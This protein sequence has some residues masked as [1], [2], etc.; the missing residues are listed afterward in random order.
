MPFFEY[1]DSVTGQPVVLRY[2]EHGEGFPLLLIAPGGMKSSIPLWK[3]APYNPMDQWVEGFRLIAMDQR[4][5]G[6]STGPIH[7]EHGWQTYLEDQLALLDHLGVD[8]FVV[9]GMCIGGSYVMQLLVRAPHRAAAGILMQSIGLDGNRDAFY[10]MYD[11][12]TDGL[13]PQR[14]GVSSS[15][16]S[17][18]RE[19]MYGNDNYLLSVANSEVAAVRA[20]LLVLMGKDLYHPESTSRR[21]ASEVPGAILVEH[22]KTGDDVAAGLATTL[23]FLARVRQ[24]ETHSQ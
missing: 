16:W 11:G 2:E 17:G 20:P 22:W 8:R 3:N 19:N 18:L 4:N 7:A 9:A 5:A 14:Q 15:D 12:W 13:R 23:D 24:A 1:P 6:E 10:Q 21:V